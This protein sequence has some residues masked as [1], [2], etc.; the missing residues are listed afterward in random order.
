MRAAFERDEQ[1][2]VSND[3]R[4]LDAMFH[5]DPRTIHYGRRSGHKEIKA[6]RAARSPMGLAR[7]LSKTVITTFGRDHAV[8]STLFHRT[9]VP[10]TSAG[11]CRPGCASKQVGRSS[12]PT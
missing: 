6:F 2:L 5:D 4:T 1:A 12:P 10:S 7:V 9:S 3:V 11:S 8:A